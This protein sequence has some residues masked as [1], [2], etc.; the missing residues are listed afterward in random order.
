[1]RYSQIFSQ[2]LRDNPSEAELTSHQLLLRAGFIRQLAAGIFTLLP[3][4]M[5]TLERIESILRQELEAIGGQ[6]ILM[7]VVNPAE[8]WKQSGRYHEIDAELSR[9]RDRNDR[10]M[11]LAMTHEEVVADLIRKEIHSYRQLPRLV[12]HIQTKWRDDPRPRAGLIRARE[13]IMKDSYSLDADN[14]G[15]DRQYR[16]HH[17]AYLNIF[18]RCDLEVISVE[19]D[20]GMMGGKLAHEFMYLTPIGEDTLI[21]CEGCNYSANRQVAI[22][23]KETPAP[24]PELPLEKV[25]TPGS[26]TIGELASYLNIKASKT[27]KAVF[28]IA[29][30]KKPEAETKDIFIFAIVR[31]DMEVNETKLAHVLQASSLRPATE[32]EIRSVGAEPGYA[33]PINLRN[34]Q[35]STEFLCVVDELIPESK[36][37]VSGANETGYHF[38]NVN[39]ARDYEGDIVADITSAQDGDPCPICGASLKAVRG[40]EVGNIFKLGT[41]FSDTLDCTYLDKAGEE[42]PIVMGSYGIGLGRLIGCI[43]E[44][45]HDENGLVLPATVAPYPIHLV[46]LSGTKNMDVH[47]L[48]EKADRLYED[49][50]RAGMDVLYDDRDESPGVKFKDADLIG[51][52]VRLTISER[53][54]KNGGVECKLRSRPDRDIYPLEQVIPMVKLQLDTLRAEIMEGVNTIG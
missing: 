35:D 50:R 18:K 23:G 33:S 2:T 41:R 25:A 1:M 38:I 46:L 4:G 15:L 34:R 13:F 45:H 22:F 28:M 31:G 44:A 9:F 16:A 39:Y 26:K 53:S 8:I 17:Q 43:A 19:G 37:L 24:E 20:V 36:N 32:E 51:L 29:N 47:L 3:L 10:E 42:K 11:V 14:E 52:P 12:Y 5:K 21:I 40:V 49:L 27:A 54:L 48:I 7:P 30:I 6:E